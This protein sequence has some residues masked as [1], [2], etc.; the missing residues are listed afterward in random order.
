MEFFFLQEGYRKR[1][2]G[3]GS[4]ECNDFFIGE[5]V[6]LKGLK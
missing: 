4:F 5:K 2:R 3:V 1:V 6:G